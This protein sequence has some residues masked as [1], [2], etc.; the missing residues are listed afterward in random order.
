MTESS[1]PPIVPPTSTP[2]TYP[3]T[4]P[5]VPA[6]PAVTHT[7][8]SPV[9]SGNGTSAQVVHGEIE[10]TGFDWKTL[11][12]GFRAYHFEI[13]LALAVFLATVVA[14]LVPKI[15]FIAFLIVIASSGWIAYFGIEHRG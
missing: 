15:S 5:P 10:K 8:V 13:Y 4:D 12:S 7:D 1:N 14:F 9:S 2:E 6:T 11:V 3:V